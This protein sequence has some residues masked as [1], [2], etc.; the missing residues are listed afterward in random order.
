M[1]VVGVGG[2]GDVMRHLHFPKSIFNP[3][4]PS[5]S[6]LRPRAPAYLQSFPERWRG[7]Q[8]HSR[9]VLAADRMVWVQGEVLVGGVKT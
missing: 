7:W 6:N 8:C 5:L 4:A 2:R 1:V 3:L 9:W